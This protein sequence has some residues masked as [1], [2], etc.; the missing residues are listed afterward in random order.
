MASLMIADE[1]IC[2]FGRTGNMFGS[3][4]FGIE[5]DI[6]TIAKGVS[7]AYSPLSAAIVARHVHDALVDLTGNTGVFSHGFTYSG[8]PVS[9]AVA[10]EAL[11]ILEERDIVGHVRKVG[12]HFQHQLRQLQ[13]NP[14]VT[15]ARGIG[16]M[17]AI[18]LAR[19][20]NPDESFEPS[21]AKGNAL[22]DRAEENGL[23]IRAVG[24]TIIIAPPLVITEIEVDY[25]F[26]RLR[27]SLDVLR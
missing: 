9:A 23:F 2:G 14:H 7:S 6:L 21:L 10:L 19:T 18:D 11:H 27:G 22:M 24:D 5:P 12:A 8:H 15:R 25:L 4:T 13:Q 1:V 20:K 16:L 3:V 26:E 17:G